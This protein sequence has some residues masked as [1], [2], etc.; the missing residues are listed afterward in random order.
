VDV[1]DGQ[2]T[3]VFGPQLIQPGGCANY[4]GSYI[5]TTSPSTDTVTATAVGPEGGIVQATASAT[6]SGDLGLGACRVTGGGNA[7]AGSADGGL[8]YD[9]TVAS[10]KYKLGANNYDRYTFGGQAGANTAL[11]P[12]PKGEWTHHQKIGPDGDFVF[13]AG[14]A[15][16][17]PGTEISNIICSDEGYCDPA[18][19]APFK[20]I[21]FDGVGTFKN[22][23]DPSVNLEDVIPGVTYHYFQ[24]HIEDLGERGNVGRKIGANGTFCRQMVQEQMYLKMLSVW[25]IVDALISR[26]QSSRVIPTFDPTTER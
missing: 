16:A 9:G 15:S 7:T 26:I 21:D 20:Q 3:T 4:S 24:V 8:T 11:P 10:G 6:C 18:R 25:L 1:V 14:T 13:H 22:I 23:K 5:P 17:P 2:A 19:P 12:Q